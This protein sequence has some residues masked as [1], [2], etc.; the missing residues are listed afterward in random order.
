MWTVVNWNRCSRHNHSLHVQQEQ[1]RRG[2]KYSISTDH[3][4]RGTVN[5]QL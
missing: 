4:R 5:H 1:E 2:A 3:A